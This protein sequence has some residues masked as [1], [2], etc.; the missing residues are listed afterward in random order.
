MQTFLPYSSFRRTA[1]VLD[2]KRL[3]KQ[4]LEAFQLLNGLMCLSKNGWRNHPA[5]RI[6]VGYNDAL[7]YYMNCMI[8]EWIK[9]GY[10]NTM[11]L[12]PLSPFQNIKWPTWLGNEKYHSAYRA[13]L[14]AK[15]YDYYSQFGWT[16]IPSI[17]VWPYPVDRRS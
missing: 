11:Q 3:G 1:S 9:R 10:H 13:I 12:Y 2:Y 5:S 7:G 6:W 15:D 16:E 17:S 8:K 4:R 14:L